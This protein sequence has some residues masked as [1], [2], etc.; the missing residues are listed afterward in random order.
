MIFD[1]PTAGKVRHLNYAQHTA[2]G[3][4][5]CERIVNYTRRKASANAVFGEIG[6][7]IVQMSA[8]CL[9]KSRKWVARVLKIGVFL[10]D[11]NDAL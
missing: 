2:S 1:P 6:H 3:E 10:R 7:R 4:R 5:V 9:G 8:K 11:S